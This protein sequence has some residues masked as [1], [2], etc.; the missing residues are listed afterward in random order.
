MKHLKKIAVVSALLLVV[1]LGSNRVVSAFSPGFGMYNQHMGDDT[2]TN[3]NET[4]QQRSEKREEH[5]NEMVQEGV[6]S[7]EQ[8]NDMYQRMENRQNSCHSTSSRGGTNNESKS[9]NSRQQM[10]GM[11]GG[12]R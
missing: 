12:R 2:S 11:M 4:K 5:I 8:A 9:S 3:E 7:E 1:I 10:H 6:I